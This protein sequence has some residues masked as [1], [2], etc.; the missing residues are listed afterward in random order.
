MLNLAFA[1]FIG[2]SACGGAGPG[3]SG[4]GTPMAEEAG[5]IAKEI[6]ADPAKR[7]DVLAAHGVDEASFRLALYNIA[8]DAELTAAY[9]AARK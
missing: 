2:L 9:E 6:G 7:A 3:L 1:L 4:S 5:K 8:A